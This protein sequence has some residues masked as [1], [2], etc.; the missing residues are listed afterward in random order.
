MN[1]KLSCIAAALGIGLAIGSAPA[2][3]TADWS[4]NLATNA[5]T[6]SAPALPTVYGYTALPGATLSLNPVANYGVNLG[7]GMYSPG[8][9]TTPDH[10][11]DNASGPATP[12]VNDPYKESLVLK[13]SGAVT[14]NQLTIGWTYNDSDVSILA[15]NGSYS[16]SGTPI[17]TS[18]AG[19]SKYENLISQGW[20]LV[21]HYGDMSSGNNDNDTAKSFNANGISS[22]YWL[23][24]AYN[25]AIGGSCTTGNNCSDSDDYVKVLAVGYKPPSKVPE[26]SALLLFGTALMGVLGLRRREKVS[27]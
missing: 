7:L 12:G 3:A 14:L 26:P 23:I 1:T 18:G 13:F 27:A 16:G 5:T 24:A 17:V 2:A 20:Q 6:G 15:Y 19:A 4:I 21:G 8:E 25:S 11:L 22:S 9:T 10:T